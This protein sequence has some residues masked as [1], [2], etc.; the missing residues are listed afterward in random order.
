MFLQSSLF[1]YLYVLFWFPIHCQC[2][3]ENSERA[4]AYFWITDSCPR[5]VKAIANE[6]P[7]EVLSLAGSIADALQIWITQRIYV[8]DMLKMA[9][10]NNLCII[11]LLI[12]QVKNRVVLMVGIIIWTKP[13]PTSM[14]HMLLFAHS[15]RRWRESNPFT[16][17]LWSFCICINCILSHLL[18]YW[19]LP[20]FSFFN[21]NNE[22]AYK[23]SLRTKLVISQL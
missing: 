22:E 5:T 9:Y 14:Y 7:F 1:I 4:F 15:F 11:Y 2:H 10:H 3:L 12:R 19:Y 23:N 20:V 13:L 18:E 6:A 21:T 17:E 8:N 16:L